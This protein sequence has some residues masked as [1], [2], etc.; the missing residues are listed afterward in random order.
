MLRSPSAHCPAIAPLSHPPVPQVCPPSWM[1]VPAA[2]PALGK[3]AR[4]ARP[5]CPATRGLASTVTKGP[6]PM[7]VWASV[8][9]LKETTV[10]LMELFTRV[11]KHSSP[12]VNT[13]AHAEM[14]R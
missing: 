14:D 9:T 6:G 4:A 7:L 12:T 8:W 10:C 2:S 13:T 1:A 11:E 5:G 3:E